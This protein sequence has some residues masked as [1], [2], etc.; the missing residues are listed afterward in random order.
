MK[1]GNVTNLRS[2]ST[3][4]AAARSPPAEG[5]SLT[6]GINDYTTIP[7]SDINAVWQAFPRRTR[8]FITRKGAAI[9]H[10][11]WW[12]TVVPSPTPPSR[13]KGVRDETARPLRPGL[14]PVG[15]DRA[16]DGAWTA[17]RRGQP[18][19]DLRGSDV[20]PR[21]HLCRTADVRLSSA[22]RRV[23]VLDRCSPTAG[24]DGDARA[25]RHR[26]VPDPG[27]APVCAMA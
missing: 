17:S 22:A 16:R 3:T 18:R 15:V 26:A 8:D 21:P 27:L 25:A 5:P 11:P 1:L 10:P 6:H 20:R 2:V 14:W 23:P 4:P 12:L 9:L 7:S 24:L 19:R 13:S